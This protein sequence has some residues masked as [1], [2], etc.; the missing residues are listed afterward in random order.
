MASPEQRSVKKLGR[1][2]TVIETEVYKPRCLY[3]SVQFLALDIWLVCGGLG[4]IDGE[5][6]LA[7]RGTQVVLGFG[8]VALHVVVIRRTCM[9]HFIDGF[10]DMLVNIV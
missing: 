5:A 6:Q 2:E 10:N 4:S 7:L 3:T 8:A 1:T 9:L